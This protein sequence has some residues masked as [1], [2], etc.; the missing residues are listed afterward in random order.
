MRVIGSTTYSRL[1]GQT[2]L[3]RIGIVQ[4]LFVAVS[5]A[6]ASTCDLD[7]P[8]YDWSSERRTGRD[9]VQLSIRQDQGLVPAL[10]AR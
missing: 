5:A 4:G 1:V 10:L 3:A 6:E 9:K 8:Q 7:R 2:Y